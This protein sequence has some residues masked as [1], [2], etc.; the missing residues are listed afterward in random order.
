[1]RRVGA[2][3]GGGVR[4]N[5]TPRRGEGRVRRL[6]RTSPVGRKRFKKANLFFLFSFFLFLSG[7]SRTYWS[8]TV[9]FL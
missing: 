3:G 7:E 8:T 4:W 5:K 1:M 9:Y 2:G 6:F